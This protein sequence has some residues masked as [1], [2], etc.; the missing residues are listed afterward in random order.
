MGATFSQE[1]LQEAGDLMGR[2]SIAKAAHVLLVPCINMQRS[3]LGGRGFEPLSED[4]VWA[5]LGTAA[6]IRGIEE[7]GVAACVNLLSAMIRNINASS[8]TQL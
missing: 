3:P 5:G 2:E 1:L 7:T 4:P 8:I 6:I